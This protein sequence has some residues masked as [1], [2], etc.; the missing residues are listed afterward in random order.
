MLRDIIYTDI[1]I[2]CINSSD[3]YFS[4]TPLFLTYP[5]NIMWNKAILY[6]LF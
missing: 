2:I 1:L 6:K 4:T 3:N 5:L